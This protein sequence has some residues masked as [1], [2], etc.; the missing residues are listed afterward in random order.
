MTNDITINFDFTKTISLKQ[1]I[2][3]KIFSPNKPQIHYLGRLLISIFFFLFNIKFRICFSFSRELINQI[4]AQFP[5]D[6]PANYYTVNTNKTFN[7]LKIDIGNRCK[8]KSS[9]LKACANSSKAPPIKTG[10]R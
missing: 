8:R 6:F 10:A 7:I 5:I 1:Q 2:A 4:S 3:R 9:T